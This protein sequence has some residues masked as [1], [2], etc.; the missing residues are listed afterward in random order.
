M[1]DIEMGLSDRSQ[2]ARQLAENIIQGG[3][4]L[5]LATFQISQMAEQGE[6][7]EEVLAMVTAFR[8]AMIPVPTDQLVVADLC[9]TGGASF[10]TFNVSTTASLILAA[11]GVP[12]AKHGNRS[13]NGCCG[14]ADLIE[15]LGG[16]ILIGPQDAGAI[17]DRL[18]FSFLYAPNF[19]PSL[20]N[21][22]TIRKRL[23]RRTIFN[24]IGPLLNPVTSRKRQLLGVYH[25]R[26][27]DLIPPILEAVGVERAMVVH[28]YP[29]MDEVSTLGPSEVVEVRG[30][31]T[32]RYELE[33][34]EYG[35]K[36]GNPRELG[37]KAPL[38]AKEVVYE[39]FR[40]AEGPL[41]DLVI[42]N[43]ACALK[44][45]G[46]VNDIEQGLRLAEA[47]LDSGSALLKLNQFL[48]LS[49]MVRI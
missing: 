37:E 23:R 3:F 27:L 24:M 45:F 43:S 11:T 20:K 36:R 32:D 5:E 48:L 9:G 12:V 41:R 34:K 17:L 29:G 21:A 26:L 10:R 39:I 2:C 42:L 25:P 28:G 15:S 4:D 30:C 33:P 38:E 7:V 16:R 40:G 6:T 22:A 14:S 18:G 19:H 8:E 47:A 31:S 49:K 35:I 44:A 1:S 13:Q 46:R